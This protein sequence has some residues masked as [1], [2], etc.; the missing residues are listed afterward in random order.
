MKAIRWHG[1]A[2]VAFLAALVFLSNECNA[3]RRLLAVKD[4]NAA[5]KTCTSKLQGVKAGCD[6]E[7][8]KHSCVKA[9]KSCVKD[10]SDW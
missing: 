8:P 1:A 5:L 6:F 3:A 10:F 9:G 4:Y 2:A 7:C